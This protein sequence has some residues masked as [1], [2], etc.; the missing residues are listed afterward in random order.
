MNT[1]TSPSE[2]SQSI[3]RRMAEC[4]EVIP[5]LRDINQQTMAD[6]HQRYTAGEAITGLVH[7][8]AEFI[9]DL[10]V[11]IWDWCELPTT[12]SAALVAVGGYGRAELHPHSDIDLLILVQEETVGQFQAA[13][14][15]FLTLLWDIKL[16]IGHSVR[17]V[18]ECV[19][20][21]RD[22]ITVLTNLM[23][24]RILTG[25][26]AMLEQL[27]KATG[28]DR[29]WDS[30]AF[31][32]AKWDEQIA[33]HRKYADTEYKLEPNIKSSPGGLRDLQTINWIAQRHFQ[34]SDVE[35]LVSRNFLTAE[36]FR[37][38]REGRDFLWLV[39]WALHMIADREEDRLLFEHQREI[40][41]MFGFV[42]SEESLA[43]EKFMQLYYR[44]AL[45]LSGLNDLVVQLYDE[46]ILRAC[47]PETIQP[48]NQRFFVRNNYIDVSNDKVFQTWPSAILEMFVLM[49]QNENIIGPRASTIRL[50]R[51]A[52]HEIDDNFRAD[53]RN[54][55]LFIQLLRS[56]HKIA[57]QLQRMNR[58]G[59]L[60]TYLPEFGRIIGK[61]QHDLFHIYTVDAHTIQVVKNMRLFAHAEFA[62]K[63]PL[64]A[65]IVK[66]LPKLD[67]L[68]IAG[69]YHDIAKGRG[70]D[71]SEKGTVDAALFCQR[72]GYDSRD[73]H[74]VVWLVKNHL[75]MSSTSQRK[76][77]TDPDVIREFAVQM[78]DQQRL[79]YL[80]A[81]TVAD[82]NATNP[83][84]WNNWRASLLR[85][86]YL[87]TR[88]ALRVS[89]ENY[90]HKQDWIDE[91][92]ENAIRMLED[93]GYD[94]D[95]VIALWDSPDQDYFLRET[96]A[97]ISWHTDSI[98][99]Y[100]DKSRPLVSIKDTTSRHHEGATQIFIH[101]PS[102]PG[103]FAVIA[104]TFE[105]LQ[106]SIQDAR[107]FRNASGYTM[108]TYVVLDV[109]GEP[110]G[111][112]PERTAKIENLLCAAISD[113]KSPKQQ[114]DKRVTRQLKHFNYPAHVKIS[115]DDNKTIVEVTT[116][117]RPG[118]LA[119]IGQVF[120]DQGLHLQNAKISSMGERVEDVFFVT[121]LEGAPLID[122]TRQEVLRQALCASL[123][124]KSGAQER[125]AAEQ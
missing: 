78:G 1:D 97:D 69:L 94:A 87:E 108:D 58:Y 7:A 3:S 79:D 2:R 51:E 8:R 107:I 72:H 93:K 48:I 55:Q 67:L 23:E 124:Q 73:T 77:T 98:A 11:A 47:D 60:G 52:R 68:Y 112:D 6:F 42:D 103:L 95:E 63:F 99:A 114:W 49:A 84:L 34:T 4:D 46:A 83:K 113:R 75:L 70:G 125:V 59:I 111:D 27:L 10:L 91:S 85:Q 74:L 64:A 53:P 62:D 31:Y 44:W 115:D 119:R 12:H 13:L 50:I 122:P 120:L 28:P 18:E 33:R 9:D 21:A 56:P 15:K 25:D 43:I 100:H 61:M 116:P 123:D 20:A 39:R 5:L 26:A 80:Y 106:L 118:V 104:T 71:H 65:S 14:E 36:E 41:E 90:A 86:L 82:I 121:D 40:A 92:K 89:I 96:A 76:D 57:T 54:Q 102:Y 19:Q 35:E 17:T 16:D 110:I 88:R 24:S 45:A 38:L 117:D 30:R 66:R 81:L 37:I 32:R 22:D 29:I 109:D 101:T 105:Q